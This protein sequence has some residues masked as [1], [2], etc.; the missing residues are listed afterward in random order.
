MIKKKILLPTKKFFKA[1]EESVDIRVDLSKDENLLRENE[2][3][4]ELNITELYNKERNDSKNYKI[5]GKIKMI[6]KNYYSGTTSYTYLKDNLYLN[7]DDGTDPLWIGTLPYNEFAFLREDVLTEINTPLSGNSISNF[8]Q[9]IST[10]SKNTKHTIITPMMAPYQNW[11]IYLSYVYSGDTSYPLK[12]TLSGNTVY[13]FIASDGIPF[14]VED[15]NSYYKLT[16]PV[17]HGIEEGEYI[18]LYGGTLTGTTSGRTFYVDNVGDEIYRSEKFVINLYKNQFPSGTTLSTVVFGK[19]CININDISGTTSQYYVHKHKVLTTVDDYILD[20]IGFE[21]SIWEDE[22]KLIFENFSREND[23]L[24]VG[25]KMESLIYDFKKPFTLSGITNNLGYTPTEV[26]TTIIFRNGNGLFEYPPKVGYKFNFHDTW[27]DQHFSGTSS[28]E[29]SLTS[30]NFTG[31][32][33]ASGYTGYTFKSGVTLSTGTTLVGAFVEYNPLELKE[34]IVSESFHKIY[35]PPSLFDY[36]QT[37]DTATFTGSSV[38]NPS[39]IYYQTHHRVKLR[40]LSPYIETFDGEIILNLPENA[41]YDDKIKKWR[42]R[43][44]YDHGYIDPDGYGT[45]FPF[46]NNTHYVTNNIN[47]YLKNE[48]NYSNKIDG[49]RDFNSRYNRNRFDC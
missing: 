9:D 20:K 35:N 26:Y 42:W 2:K 6:F 14:R 37:G 43:D 24:V 39:G 31:N 7:T 13:D 30:V 46:V 27:I 15:Y 11:N 22:R 32:T 25:N 38:N 3:N 36:G 33:Y 34:R 12:Y 48:T 8:T 49:L 28:N 47:F 10:T 23:V 18:T 4:I 17:E 44:L 16:S 40:E 45:D 41:K 5:Y 29:T 19:R 1:P 21:S